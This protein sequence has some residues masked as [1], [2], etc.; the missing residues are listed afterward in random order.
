MTPQKIS[1]NRKKPK[2]EGAQI[3]KKKIKKRKYSISDEYSE[4]SFD[5]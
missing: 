3:L 5:S 4:Q 1:K 2:I